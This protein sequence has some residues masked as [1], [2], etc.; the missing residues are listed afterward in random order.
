[1]IYSKLELGEVLTPSK[2]VEETRKMAVE[3]SWC[4][5]GGGGRRATVQPSDTLVGGRLQALPRS[6]TLANSMHSIQTVLR[7]DW[8]TVR[9]RS[10]VISQ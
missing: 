6:S 10:G 5:G 3:S 7:I 8:H 9:V 1:M 2:V 4:G